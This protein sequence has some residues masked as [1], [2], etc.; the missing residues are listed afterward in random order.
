MKIKIA[1]FISILLIPLFSLISYADTI[2]LYGSIDDSSSYC[3]LLIDVMQNDSS[4]DPF[5][6]YVVLRAGERDY[7]VYF[8]EDISSSNLVY[9]K[10]VPSY[11]QVSANITRGTASSLSINTNGY[12]YV[13][14]VEG[15]LRSLQ[16]DQYKIYSIIGV[17]A[18]L[19]ILLILFRIFRKT[20]GRKAKYYSVR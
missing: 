8:G 3:N 20:E 19:I 17:A 1:F 6:Q 5:Y 12:Y 16:A 14:N 7:R 10:Y 9:Y 18:I 15:S 2:N 4:Y 13:G 11:Q